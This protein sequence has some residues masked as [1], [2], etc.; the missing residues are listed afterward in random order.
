MRSVK[1]S[2]TSVKAF[3]YDSCRTYDSRMLPQHPRR[4]KLTHMSRC[5]TSVRHILQT[6]TGR[7]DHG[8]LPCLFEDHAP[9]A[10]DA[11]RAR[12]LRAGL[13][14]SE[15]QTA[16]P[17]SSRMDSRAGG[18][19]RMALRAAFDVHPVWDDERASMR[20]RSY[21]HEVTQ[22]IQPDPEV[23]RRAPLSM[24]SLPVDLQRL[25]AFGSC[26]GERAEGDVVIPPLAAEVQTRRPSSNPYLWVTCKTV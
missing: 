10:A 7:R 8:R 2:G 18:E 5:V 1:I 25:A 17:P 15:L 26:G 21:R 13:P 19:R 16:L 6:D 12:R 20:S 4:R 14:L 22:C 9:L 23:H 24:R 3:A 11:H